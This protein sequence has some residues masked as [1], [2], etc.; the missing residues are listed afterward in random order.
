MIVTGRRSHRAPFLPLPSPSRPMR[1]H[2]ALVVLAAALAACRGTESSGTGGDSNAPGGTI[3]I[4]APEPN[5]LL[6]TDAQTSSSREIIDNVYDHL[7]EIGPKLNTVGD[8][9]FEPR[10]AER[11]DWAPDSLSIAFH[12][13]PRARFHDGSP[14][15]AADVRASFGLFKDPKAAA[16]IAPLLANVDSVTVRD[17]LTAV[18]WFHT[19]QPEEFYSLVYNVYV[20]PARA[21]AGRSLDQLAGAPIARAPIGSGRFRFVRWDAGSRVEMIADT[22]N[23]RGRAKLDRIVFSV[24]PDINAGLTQFRSGQ[25]DFIEAIP[26][27]QIEAVDSAPSTRAVPYPSL[28]YGFLAFNLNDPK[29]HKQPHPIFGDV[30]VRRA[31]SMGVDRAA[32]LR[33]VFGSRGR[34]GRGPFPASA[35]FA[36]TSVAPPPF[37]TAHAA[38]LLDSAGWKRGADGMRSKN[39]KALAFSIISPSSSLPRHRYAVLLQDQFKKLG[40]AVSLD[41]MDFGTYIKKQSSRDFDASLAAFST[42][43]SPSGMKQNWGTPGGGT[44]SQNVTGYSSPKFDAILDSA[45]ASF[46]PARSTAYMKQADAVVLRDAPAI[47]LYDVL[48]VAGASRRIQTRGIRADEW[49]AGLADWTIPPSQRIARDKVGLGGKSQ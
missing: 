30:R 31:L 14:V 23:Y 35:P 39:G 29:T 12:L 44:E 33:N 48:T 32:M 15:R 19:H 11:W 25:A 42:D 37:D 28:Q 43:P 34:I 10:V 5:S 45:L 26:P 36:D 2:R 13:N 9:G 27:D 16:S 18:A 6:P 1:I 41:E 38:A 17:S 8:A 4:A 49:W 40:A 24:I 20:M 3:V 46:D 22:A 47:W 7:A 21:L